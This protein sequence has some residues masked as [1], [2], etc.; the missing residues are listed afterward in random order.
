MP[1]S[2]ADFEA[3]IQWGIQQNVD[4]ILNIFAWKN[5][6]FSFE[7]LL[8]LEKL[9]KQAE[10]HNIL[11][12]NA[13]GDD[14]EGRPEARFPARF[15]C[16]LSIGAFDEETK[17]AFYSVKSHTLDFLVPVDKTVLPGL[18]SGSQNQEFVSIVSGLAAV[19]G[20]GMVGGYMDNLKQRGEDVQI[21]QIRVLLKQKA[22]QQYQLIKPRDVA[23]GWGV[24]GNVNRN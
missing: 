19:V 4:L 3:A 21:G 17:Q 18:L 13:C 20:G 2:Y 22:D 8:S 7:E 1:R 12:I 23:F 5:S 16:V 14:R 11:W 9:T 15:A 24:L 6:V 10:N